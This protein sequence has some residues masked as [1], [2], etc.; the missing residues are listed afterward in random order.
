MSDFRTDSMSCEGCPLASI[1]FADCRH[2]SNE[3][4][5]EVIIWIDEHD[6]QIREDER[7]KIIAKIRVG[8]GKFKTF[9]IDT[10]DIHKE[11]KYYDAHMVQ[12]LLSNIVNDIVTEDISK[13]C[14]IVMEKRFEAT[15]DGIRRH[16]DTYEIHNYTDEFGNHF[17]YKEKIN[18]RFVG[19]DH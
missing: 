10:E 9:E 6:K 2:I 19:I 15:N 12:S 4:C 5:K 17:K 14:D 13:P 1:S 11:I 7:N 8:L 16:I 18:S 3:D